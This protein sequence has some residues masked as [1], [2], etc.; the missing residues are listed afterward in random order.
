MDKQLGGI[1]EEEE[2]IKG[3]VA[4]LQTCARAADS[5]K[6]ALFG[7]EAM[8]RELATVEVTDDA[9]KRTIIQRLVRRVTIHTVGEQGHREP[10]V[11][12]AYYFGPRTNGVLQTVYLAVTSP[13][14][15]ITVSEKL[16][17]TAV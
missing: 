5:S 9:T 17:P 8:L 4:A 7:A 11:M 12:I 1:A 13:H 15:V 10:D 2:T 14:V 16:R 3:A 6:L